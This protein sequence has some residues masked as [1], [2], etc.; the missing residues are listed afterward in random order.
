MSLLSTLPIDELA[1]AFER[2]FGGKRKCLHCPN[3]TLHR[4]CTDCHRRSQNR[5]ATNHRARKARCKC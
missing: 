3:M 1:E 4:V 2:L 5:A